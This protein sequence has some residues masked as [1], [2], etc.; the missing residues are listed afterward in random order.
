MLN[1]CRVG[2]RRSGGSAKMR[3]RRAA[4]PK[5]VLISRA[6]DFPCGAQPDNC[7]RKYGLQRRDPA[8]GRKNYHR[9]RQ[10]HRSGKSHPA[11]HPRRR[12]RPGHLGRQRARVRRGGAKS[13][14]R[15]T[16]DRL[17]RGF[18]RRGSRSRNSTTGCRTT[19][20]RRSRN[21]SSASKA[22][23]PRPSAAASARSTSR[24]ARCSI[25]T[26]ACARCNGSPAC[27][28]P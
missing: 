11:V 22:R 13:L 24:C 15:Q 17:V 19:R 1:T 16:Q 8:R 5:G 10:A 20:S 26:S 9:E 6:F 14:R 3:P 2:D 27:P 25:S 28:R 21:I 4:S 7:L 18:R 23:S 12:H